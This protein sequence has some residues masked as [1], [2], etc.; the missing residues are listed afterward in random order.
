[1]LLVKSN[2]VISKNVQC[3]YKTNNQN[4]FTMTIMVF[5]HI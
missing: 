1:L 5:Y 4:I 2:R 3:D